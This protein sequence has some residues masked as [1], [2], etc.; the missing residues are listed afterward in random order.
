MSVRRIATSIVAVA[1]ALSFV[2]AAVGQSKRYLTLTGALQRALEANPRLT[3]AERDIAMAGGRKLQAGVLPNPE[4]SFEADNVFGTG[5]YRGTGAAEYTLQL[6]Q[7]IELGG[8]RVA[9]VAAGSAELEAYRW[10]REAVRLEILS[11]TAIAYFSVL[12][13]QRRIAIYDQHIGALQRLTPFLQKRVEAGAS[14]PSEVARAQ[15]AADL[16]RAER[17]RARATLAIARLELTTLMGGTVPDFPGVVGDLGRIGRP[18]PFHVLQKALQQ[19]PQLIRF[20]ALRAQ[21]DAELLIARLKPIPDLRAGVS[22]RHVRETRDDA[23]RIGLSIPIP[24]F[25]QNR[26]GIIEADQQ[27]AKVEAEFAIAV[28]QLTLTLGRAY[29]NMIAAARE[30]EILRAGAIPNVKQAVQSM[31]EGYEQGRFTLLELLDMQGAAAQTAVRELDA[32][33]NFHV[34]LATIEG[35]TGL[36]FRLNNERTK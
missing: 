29:E 23:F 22:W 24:L 10:Q 35:L 27:R 6:S 34:A 17:E 31:E 16:V 28:S 18:Q 13:A 11:D 33:M 32:L 26:G 20:T 21:R 36:G 19:N 12:A 3:A 9:R 4:I 14:P 30:I 25:D 7:L 5:P 8:K 2:S 1:C 15:I